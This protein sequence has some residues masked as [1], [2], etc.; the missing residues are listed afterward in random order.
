MITEISSAANPRIKNIGRLDKS[1]E[2]KKQGLFV[3]EGIREV[4]RCLE[5]GYRID[6]VFWCP[7]LTGKNPLPDLGNTPV[8]KVPEQ[9]YSKIAY[10]ESTEGLVALVKMAPHGLN[11]L[12]VLK[13]KF[14]LVVESIEKPGNLGAILRTADAVG[15]DAI[16]ICDP[17]TDIYNPNVMR[18]GIGSFFTVPIAIT[19]N[20]EALQWMQAK[21]LKIFLASPEAGQNLFSVNLS[22]PV[23]LVFGTEDKGLS[24]FWRGNKEVQAFS[25][26]MLGEM[27]SLNV[28]NSVAVV[29]YECLRQNMA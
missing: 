20:D 13:K 14:V 25:I 18:S 2:R 16:I 8:F 10:R 27:D 4:S 17:K 12:P 6:S 24:E 9:V 11:D 15:V 26:P 21:G 3:V 28:S 29:L 5:A 23:A 19:N 22:W 7:S 1:A